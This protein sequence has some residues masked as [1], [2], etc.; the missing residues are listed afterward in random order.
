MSRD[1]L[2]FLLQHLG[3]AIKKLILKPSQQIKY[4]GLKIDTLN[5]NLVLTKKKMEK[6]ILKCQNILSDLK[7]F[8][9]D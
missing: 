6:V 2:T 9:R 5:M 8:L 3:F 7:P 4:L 1:N